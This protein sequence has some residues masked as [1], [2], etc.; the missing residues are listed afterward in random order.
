MNLPGD[1]LGDRVL[2]EFDRRLF[3]LLVEAPRSVVFLDVNE[4]PIDDVSSVDLL[5]HE[6]ECGSALPVV[7]L[8][9]VHDGWLKTLLPR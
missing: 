1:D 3:R 5:R 2:E 8:A 6:V 7:V 9:Y 4:S